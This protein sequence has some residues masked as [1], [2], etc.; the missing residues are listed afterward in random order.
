[1][2]CNK[3]ECHGKDHHGICSK[4]PHAGDPSYAGAKWTDTPCSRCSLVDTLV[5]GH[6]RVRSFE[7][8]PPHLVATPGDIAGGGSGPVYSAL[9]TAISALSTIGVHA[10]AALV[11][12]AAGCSLE[13]IQRRT[14]SHFGEDITIQGLSARIRTSED[15]LKRWIQRG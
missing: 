3:P 9:R 8:V 13:E 12:K 15:T 6:G 14:R 2:K 5:Q 7:S 10:L 1:M 4:C 11:W